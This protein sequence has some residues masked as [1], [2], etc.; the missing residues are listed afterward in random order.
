MQSKC[1]FLRVLLY[2]SATFHLI[3]EILC[4]IIDLYHRDGTLFPS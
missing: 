1:K 4:L 2:F 3:P